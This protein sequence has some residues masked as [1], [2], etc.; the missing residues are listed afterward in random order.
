MELFK[1]D[2]SFL[3]CQ[4]H[5]NYL[6]SSNI[7]YK[8]NIVFLHLISVDNYIT[9]FYIQFGFWIK[10]LISQ[11][12]NYSYILYLKYKF[13]FLIEIRNLILKW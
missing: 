7:R 9:M 1:F 5:V 13:P 6:I 10:I 12:S 11:N 2:I 8:I 4:K 3:I